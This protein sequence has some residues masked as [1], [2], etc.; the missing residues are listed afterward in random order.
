MS[1]RGSELP[2]FVH[3]IKES[4]CLRRAYAHSAEAAVDVMYYHM[5][6]REQ[7]TYNL[8]LHVSHPCPHMPTYESVSHRECKEWK[9]D[10]YS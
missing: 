6:S 7:K 1:G 4:R 3:T 10:A 9:L 2:A 5:Y 8:G